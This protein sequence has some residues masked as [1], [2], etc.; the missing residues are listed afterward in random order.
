MRL[1][2]AFAQLVHCARDL[3]PFGPS[4]ALHNFEHFYA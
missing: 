2:L 3:P 4:L 1:D